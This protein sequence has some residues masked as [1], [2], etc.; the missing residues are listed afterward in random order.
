M[1]RKSIALWG[2]V[3]GLGLA[4]A[5]AQ[6]VRKPHRALPRAL[7]GVSLGLS[8]SVAM[9][10][11]K[12][13][14]VSREFKEA[15]GEG[16]TMRSFKAP[17]DAQGMIGRFTNG[18]LRRLEV[19]YPPAFAAGVSWEEFVKRAEN[20]YQRAPVDEPQAKAKRA[21]FAWKDAKT[22][23]TYTQDSS[24]TPDGGAYYYVAIQDAGES[25]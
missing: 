12:A 13:V 5:A 15:L 20:D 14:D 3:I 18:K 24:R 17:Q 25:P 23:I 7:G 9:T 6:Q 19:T 4:P 1:M 22:R 11:Y 2:L 21:I 16:E 8:E 10:R